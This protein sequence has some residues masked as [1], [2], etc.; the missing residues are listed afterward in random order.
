[1]PPEEQS[2]RASRDG[3][4]DRWVKRAG[5]GFGRM[6]ERDSGLESPLP[7]WLVALTITRLRLN[8][9]EYRARASG[10]V[11]LRMRLKK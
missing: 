1:M 5:V 6:L 3:A 9:I 2:P 8:S 10:W 7:S 11:R 4:L